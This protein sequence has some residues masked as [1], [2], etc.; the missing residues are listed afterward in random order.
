VAYC[1]NC[2]AQVG[3]GARFCPSCGAAVASAGR[4]ATAEQ[5]ATG[6]SGSAI[7]SLILGIA[8]FFIFPVVPSIAAIVLGRSAQKEIAQKPGLGGHGLATAGIVLGWIGVGIGI[9]ALLVFF[10]FLAALP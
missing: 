3:A 6:T 10:L 9:F 2:G 5:R 1:A 8:G 7:A 4:P